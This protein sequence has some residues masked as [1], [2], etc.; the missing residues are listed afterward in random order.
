MNEQQPKAID[1]VCGMQVDPATARWHCNYEGRVYYFCFQ[2]CLDKFKA[3]PQKY[4]TGKTL[5]PPTL[6]ESDSLAPRDSPGTATGN[7]GEAM[8]VCPM[9]PEVKNARPGICPKCGMALEPETFQV[10]NLAEDKTELLDMLRRFVLA[11]MLSIPTVILSMSM[12]ARTAAMRAHVEAGWLEMILASPVVLWA[13]APIWQRFWLSLK[14]RCANMFTLIGAGTGIAYLFS[15]FALL[16]QRL[17]PAELSQGAGPPVYFETAATIVALVLLGQVLELQA[18]AR[19]GSAVKSLLALSPPLAYRLDED[20]SESAVPL[21]TVQ[22]NDQLR[23]R[24]GERVPVDGLVTA[25]ESLVDESLLT[26]EPY[27]QAKQ[28]GDTV[29]GGTIN[30]AGSFTMQAQ[31]V[32]QDT[33]LAQIVAMVSRAQRSRAPVQNLA[34][35]LSAYFVPAVALLAVIT[36]CAWMLLGPPPRLLFAMINAV[37][38]LI[39]ACPCALGLA[40]PMAIMVAAG[41]GAQAGILIKDAAALEELHK[42]QVVALDKTGTLTE[43]KPR[44]T[45]VFAADRFSEPE[46]LRAAACLEVH[47]EHPLAKAIVEAAEQRQLSARPCEQFE[48][49]PG[50]GVIG[51]VADTRVA[52]GN[53]RLLGELGV[54]IDRAIHEHISEKRAQRQSTVLVAFGNQCAGAISVADAIKPTSKVA[55]DQLRKRGIETVMITGD[56]ATTAQSVGRELGFTEKE[57]FAG[58]LPQDK[59]HIIDA[60]KASGKPVAM[61]GDGINDAVA[62][63]R[64]DVGIAIAGGADVAMET[65]GIVIVKGDVKGILRALR[66]SRATFSNI[67]QNLFFAFVYNSLG[68]LIAAGVLFPWTGWLLSPMLAA[69]AMSLSSVCVIFNALRLYRVQ[70]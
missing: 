9:H 69:A 23:V 10:G 46:I 28:P 32:G 65:A 11:A 25:G 55:L 43:G 31:R 18:R 33:L 6:G 62:L 63:A 2:G 30:A 44:V 58:V 5:A 68:T 47:S 61:A 40:T 53:E 42:I 54:I 1:P 57:I 66:L 60:L 27:P 50:Q 38:V 12:G 24:P 29:F 17:I 19:A 59:G 48:Y 37:S 64:A 8:Y 20:G 22:V 26:G 51:L 36:F 14:N 7:D 67:R 34:D 45:G 56:D 35:R 70:I 13:G 39:I 52:A 3:D 21:H 49:R 41:R 16:G 15:I 4:L